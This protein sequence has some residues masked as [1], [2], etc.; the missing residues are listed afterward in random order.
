MLK[1]AFSGCLTALLVAAFVV[2]ALAE[3]DAWTLRLMLGDTFTYRIFFREKVDTIKKV[4][5]AKNGKGQFVLR[6]TS[7]ATGKAATEIYTPFGALVSGPAE[8]FWWKD[9]GHQYYRQV[10]EESHNGIASPDMREGT[11]WGHWYDV[12]NDYGLVKQKRLVKCTVGDARQRTIAAGSFA[13]KRVVCTDRVH[14]RQ[15]GKATIELFDTGTGFLFAELR[16][17]GGSN[18]GKAGFELT[19]FTLMPRQLHSLK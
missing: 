7:K 5:A 11:T 3:D 6:V 1:A 12:T 14:D 9:T 18:P 4:V 8:T 13:L 15:Y 19:E 2:P 16:S 10:S 17:W